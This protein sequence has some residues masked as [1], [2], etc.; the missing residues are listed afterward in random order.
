M[1]SIQ[2]AVGQGRPRGA[3][4]RRSNN[5][6]YFHLREH[7][8]RAHRA[9]IVPDAKF[10]DAGSFFGNDVRMVIMNDLV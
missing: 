3:F 4:P 8:H 1:S 7:S 10:C 9:H 6:A 5:A 2:F